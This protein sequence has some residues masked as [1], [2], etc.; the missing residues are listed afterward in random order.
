MDFVEINFSSQHTT[1]VD[2]AELTEPNN[3]RAFVHLAVLLCLDVCIFVYVAWPCSDVH[4]LVHRVN[5][6]VF[7]FAL[8][9]LC[10]VEWVVN[11]A[12]QGEKTNYFCPF[13]DFNPSFHFTLR[14]I[15]E[16]FND[17]YN[18]AI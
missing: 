16:T 9:M 15:Y 7:V 1:T 14:C 3:N 4:S 17:V 5:S 12:K 13:Y 8:E 11:L 10:V 2:I 18:Y 6:F